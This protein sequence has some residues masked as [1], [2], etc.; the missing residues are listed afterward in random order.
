MSLTAGDLLDAEPAETE[1][2]VAVR[3]PVIE[4]VVTETD[5]PVTTLGA[6]VIGS[7]LPADSAL[8]PWQT[9]T[10]RHRV[11][12]AQQ[13]LPHGVSFCLSHRSL[14]THPP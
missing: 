12:P 11:V 1:A 13:M 10:P 2:T 8:P 4:V 3:L 5:C 7:S 9:P 6:L 14:S